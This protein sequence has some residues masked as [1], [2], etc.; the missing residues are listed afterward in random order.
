MVY[1]TGPPY[2]VRPVKDICDHYTNYLDLSGTL[3][4]DKDRLLGEIDRALKWPLN[5]FRP[6]F[7]GNQ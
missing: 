4:E 1:K 2:R 5:H 6:F 3:P 7:I